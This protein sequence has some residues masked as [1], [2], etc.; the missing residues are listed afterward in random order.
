[1]S[2]FIEYTITSIAKTDIDEIYTLIKDEK[3]VGLLQWQ[4][5]TSLKKAIGRNRGFSHCARDNNK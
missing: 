1:M 3:D 5:T 2:S 4:K